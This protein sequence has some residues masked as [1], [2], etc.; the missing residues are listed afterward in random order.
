MFFPFASHSIRLAIIFLGLIGSSAAF[1]QGV[2][3]LN[4]SGGSDYVGFQAP[5]S[6]T[7]DQLWTLPNADGANDNVFV[8]NGSGVLSFVASSA[9]AGDMKSDGTVA[10]TGPLRNSAGSAAA[11]SITFNSATNTGF[12]SAAADAVGIAFGGVE[13]HRITTTTW[14][15][16][17]AGDA[18][19]KLNAGSAAS[20]SFS[21][22]GDTDTGMWRTAADNWAFGVAG[23]EKFRVDSS[24]NFGIANTGTNQ[25]LLD[26]NGDIKLRKNSSLPVACAAGNDGLIALTSQDTLCVCKGGSTAWVKTS[27]G[28]SACAW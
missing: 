18:Y 20:P 10:M 2:L 28:V 16:L 7:V 14:A 22:V 1:A 27:D 21:W 26:I 3:K 13:V 12:F 25:A 6:L 15:G 19:M 8:T 23:A 11:P 24:G 4:E 9:G 5:G 17:N